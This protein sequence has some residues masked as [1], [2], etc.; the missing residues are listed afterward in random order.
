MGYELTDDD[1]NRLWR[2]MFGWAITV[3]PNDRIDRAAVRRWFAALPVVALADVERAMGPATVDEAKAA[4]D[5]CMASGG[6]V[7]DGVSAAV[8]AGVDLGGSR[9]DRRPRGWDLIRWRG[10]M[11]HLR[12]IAFV[13]T[14]VV[15]PLV[16]AAFARAV[17]PVAPDP[18]AVTTEDDTAANLTYLSTPG[19]QTAKVRAV[20]QADRARVKSRVGS[21]APAA[22]RR[23]WLTVDG[24]QT[25]ID[26]DVYT[27][28]VVG[29]T[30]VEFRE[31][32]FTTLR[33][34]RSDGLVAHVR[35]YF[36]A[37]DLSTPAVPAAEARAK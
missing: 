7:V 27:S 37:V 16:V 2:M 35:A 23:V 25:L 11:T 5:A 18:W 14:I 10:M 21:A 36:G 31:S 28:V 4:W 34:P 30:E 20:I 13:A 15:S 26:L 29:A 1:I 12:A 32:G 33:V 8:D 24:G 19:S 17:R 3:E 6:T 22:S 9:Q